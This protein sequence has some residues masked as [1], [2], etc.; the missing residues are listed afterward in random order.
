M[1]IEDDH[2][3]HIWLHLNERTPNIITI[4]RLESYIK[5]QELLRNLIKQK[6]Q[7]QRK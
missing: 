1:F 5:L 4:L 3:D 2:D 6:E 7:K